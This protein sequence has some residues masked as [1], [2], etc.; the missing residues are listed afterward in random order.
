MTERAI[1]SVPVDRDLR[2]YLRVLRKRKWYL[3]LTLAAAVGFAA[4]ITAQTKPVYQ[5]GATLFVGQRQIPREDFEQD[6]RIAVAVSDLSFRLLASYSEMLGSRS[7]AE[8]AI[9]EFSIDIS[10]RELRENIQAEPIPGTQ[11]IQLVYASSD[12]TLAQRVANGIADMFVREVSRLDPAA[13]GGDP[14]VKVSILD[15]ATVPTDPVSPQPLRNVLIAV[16]LGFAAGMGLVFLADRLDVTVKHSSEIEKMGMAVLGS[17]PTL[18]IPRGVLHLE[19]DPQGLG[20]EAFRKLRTSL[21]FLGVE[22]PLRTILV[23]SPGPTEG[24]TTIALNLAAAFALGGLRTLLLEADLR[25]PSLH[26]MFGMRGTRGLTT[27]IVGQVTPQEAV[28]STDVPNLS[29]MLAGAIPPN[30]VE[31]LGSEQMSEL[32][33]RLKQMYDVVILDSPPLIPVADPAV[34]ASR[35]DGVILVVRAGKTDRRRLGDSAQILERVGGRL[36]GVVANFLRRGEEDLDYGYYQY[37]TP[38]PES[39]PKPER[40]SRG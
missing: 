2:D 18:D 20:G 10:P 32:L 27:A 34:L 1:H 29:V 21:G 14:V 13:G 7:I 8:S 16:A 38:E 25:R 30:P 3:V 35:C 9:A 22:L 24:K 11:I 37:A 19:Q 4:F 6:A 39:S 36:L 12:P 33:G 23:T 28:A 15:R 5:A 31:L 17:V 26:L 40:A